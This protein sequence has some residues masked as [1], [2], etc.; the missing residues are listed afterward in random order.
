MGHSLTHRGPASFCLSPWQHGSLPHRP[1]VSILL[2]FYA[3]S[4]LIVIYSVLYA[5]CVDVSPI[6]WRQVA[7]DQLF[8]SYSLLAL[9][10]PL[11]AVGSLEGSIK[12]LALDKQGEVSVATPY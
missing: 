9:H 10:S 5:A 8:S 11:L 1:R 3:V 12:L 7:R 4:E 2:Y 6:V